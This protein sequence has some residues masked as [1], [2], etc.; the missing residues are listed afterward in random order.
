MISV[1]IPNNFIQERTYVIRVILEEFLGQECTIKTDES[2]SDYVLTLNNNRVITIEDHFFNK[3]KEGGY[4][5]L[6]S[7]PTN[8]KSGIVDFFGEFPI[9]SLFGPLETTY[10]KNSVCIE[11]DIFAATFFMLTRWEEAV[12]TKRDVN[13]RFPARES[14]A[15]KNSFINR[16]IVNEYVE[17][18]WKAIKVLCPSATRLKRDFNFLLTHDVDLPKLWWSPKDFIKSIGGA[19]LKRK[20][21]GE[22]FNLTKQYI[23]HNDPFDVFD[24][25]MDLSDQYN[26]KSHFFFMSGGT[27]IKDNFYK[28][29]HP[30][31]KRLINKI[32]GRNHKIGF[33]PSFNSYNDIK[34]FTKELNL[35][36]KISEV[37]INTGRHH[38][39]RFEVPT[40]WQIWEDSN[41]QWDSTL[42]YHDKEGFRCGVCY[43]FPVFNIITRKR[44]NLIERPLTVMEG[45]FMTY[46]DSNPNIMSSRI[47]E[48]ID[49]TR[50]YNGE[51]VFL[52]HN[53][54][55]RNKQY[56][57]V[58]EDVLRYV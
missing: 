45:S 33:H 46:Q 39:L 25:M 7:I 16:P 32:K 4:L 42:S 1:Q 24:W 50:F 37:E 34:Q 19:L 55:F 38:F 6:K 41:M 57:K 31:I 21:L 2:A 9:V 44:L 58:Y 3:F 10:D 29:D 11:I 52:W 47:K 28:I 12:N 53:S 23:N 26:I 14:L 49:T 13:G 35:L 30:E 54:A 8:V 51:F 56:N 5:E 27:S 40:T 48:L 43:P 22:A 36:K 15:V 17:L 18:L 20:S